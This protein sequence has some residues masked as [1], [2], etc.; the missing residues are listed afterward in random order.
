[1]VAAL[2]MYLD[3]V[4]SQRLRTLWDAMEEAGIPS[5][6]DLTHRR[7]RP[8]VSL[9]SAPALDPDAVAAAL[10]GITVAPPLRLNLNFVGTFV[11]RVLWLG[12]IVTSEL[13]EHHRLVYDALTAGGVDVDPLYRPGEWAPH[14]TVSM[15]VPLRQMTDAIRLCMDTLPIEATVTSAAV[16]DYARDIYRPL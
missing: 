6:R 8:H 5:L 15:R 10:R 9:F 3:P 2:E 12:P 16:A 14:C 13:L 7:H 11:G 1:M 4:A